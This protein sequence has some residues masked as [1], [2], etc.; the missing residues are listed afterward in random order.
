MNV[1]GTVIGNCWPTPFLFQPTSVTM[2]PSSGTALRSSLRMRS[3]RIGY[4]SELSLVGPVGGEGPAA[5]ARS[6]RAARRAIAVRHARC[7]AAAS[8]PS[9]SFA[10]ATTPSSVGKLR[11]ISATSASM[12][13]RRVGGIVER[14]ARIPRARVRFGEARADGEDQVG[15][16][17]LLVGDR[18]AP[19][20]GHAEQQRMVLAQAR[21]CPSACARSGSSSASA[22]AASSA[23][24]RADS[25]PP[26]A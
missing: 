16:A 18:R 21:P 17:A 7:A 6:R 3:G 5:A 11:P 20:A 10:S 13:I 9:A 14:E 26:P 2:K 1:P 4:W 24:A 8:A 19:E 12:W 15:G 25:T 22:S 23:V